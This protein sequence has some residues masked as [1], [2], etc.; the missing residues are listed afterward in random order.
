MKSKI[1]NL[2]EVKSRI[3]FYCAKED[4]CQ[5]QVMDKLSDYGVS[6]SVSEEI[7]L[8]LILEKYVDEERY[9]R[10]FCSGKFKIKKWGRRKIIF[11]LKKK[12]VSEV[13]IQKGLEEIDEI[14]YLQTLQHLLEKKKSMINDTNQFVRKKKMVDYVVRKG[15][16][17]DLVWEAIHNI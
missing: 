12:K 14:A 16:E 6:S 15:F 7:L 2:K 1:Y 4:R 8:D 3:R 9:A 17:S 10:S 5:Q 13:C 11:E